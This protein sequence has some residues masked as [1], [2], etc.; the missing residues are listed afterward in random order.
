MNDILKTAIG[1]GT[2]VLFLGAGASCTSKNK[3]DDYIPM[4]D[5][6]AQILCNSAN[7]NYNGEPLKKV[8]A[9]ASKKLGGGIVSVLQDNLNHCSPSNEYNILASYSWAR[10]YT[11][12]IDDAF[13]KALLDNSPQRINPRFFSSW[14]SQQDQTFQELDYIKLNGCIKHPE[15]G[16]IFSAKEYASGAAETSAW[17]K[18]VAC[19]FYNYQFIFIGT[20][21]DEPLFQHMLELYQKQTMKNPRRGFVITPS[22][23]DIEKD[24]LDDFNI[25][26]ISG[27]LKNFTDWLSSEYPEPLKPITLNAS[28]N[29]AVATFL[30]LSEG[31][32]DEAVE[33]LSDVE[34]VDRN[35]LNTAY[36]K[37][38][39]GEREYY[40]GFKPD[41]HD[42][43]HEVPAK[44]HYFDGFLS[45]YEDL[46]KGGFNVMTVVGA[47]GCGKTT[48]LMQCA[49]YLS[50]KSTPVYYLRS[51][52]KDLVK[53]VKSLELI[54]EQGFVLFVDRIA[55]YSKDLGAYLQSRTS[56]KWI[57]VGSDTLSVWE[58]RVAAN[59]GQFCKQ[60]FEIGGIDEKDAGAILEKVKEYGRWA[61]LEKMT[62]EARVAE[63]MVKAKKQLL[64]GLLETTRGVGYE[65]IIEEDYARIDSDEEQALFLLVGL[66]T[67][68]RSTLSREQVAK[69]LASMGVEV[70]VD[71]LL[72]NLSGIVVERAGHLS[73][74]HASYVKHIFDK[75]VDKRD[76]Q[77]A[78]KALLDSYSIY[79]QPLIKYINAN[80]AIVYKGLLNHKF[81]KEIFKNN[82][83]A[84]VD[85][86]HSYEKI[87]QSD[88][89]YW[90]QYGL[91][92]R[93]FNE[94]FEAYDK[95]SVAYEV[96]PQLYAEH[97]LGQQKLILSLVSVSD[98][99]SELFFKEGMDMLNKLDVQNYVDDTYPIIT[100][101]EGHIKYEKR[102]NGVEAARAIA[103]KY[104]NILD[105]RKKN[106]YNDIRLKKAWKQVAT[107]GT[108]GVMWCSDLPSL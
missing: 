71:S 29:P 90:L 59:L 108:T 52:T 49:L 89:H 96:Y 32:K 93:D 74:R 8:Y 38:E 60:P 22:A 97:A 26:H 77:K 5:D 18:Q 34:V 46:R 27:T 67:R 20:K 48:V 65:Q 24:D 33:I 11:I 43:I 19:D 73:A 23:T 68:H 105:E 53:V 30:R 12:N 72:R 62:E 75:L 95:I 14:V 39:V 55:R 25:E 57:V 88:G 31:K 98:I 101:A 86:Y 70:S 80:D 13:D 85:I 61:R 99:K 16:F 40:K 47:A 3:N 56:P 100:M 76:L 1:N 51:L 106:N 6:L 79:Q 50:T 58:K 17:Y 44:T 42:I 66:A 4:G 91:S 78:I 87:F 54:N 21:L 9:S 41:W 81:L 2:A 103:K 107:F 63:F 35:S 69:A 36:F 28:R 37:E 64:I 10:I 102:K 92:L 104:A 82:K 15:F 45:H 7:I 84:V 94:Q 83:D